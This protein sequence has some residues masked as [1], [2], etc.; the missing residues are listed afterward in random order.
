MFFIFLRN[1]LSTGN[2]V[3]TS[4]YRK[5]NNLTFYERSS[6]ANGSNIEQR[7]SKKVIMSGYEI[8]V[9]DDQKVHFRNLKYFKSLCFHKLIIS[10]YMINKRFPMLLSSNS[11]SQFT[12]RILYIISHCYYIEEVVSTYHFSF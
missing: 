10:H 3:L 11:F 2:I 8:R 5:Q 4:N 7:V 9:I 1:F 12:K 6:Q